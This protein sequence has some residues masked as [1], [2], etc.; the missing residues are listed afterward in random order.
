MQATSCYDRRLAAALNRLSATRPSY[1]SYADI[2]RYR[3]AYDLYQYPAMMVPAMLSDLLSVIN[4]STSG[5]EK[6]CDPFL[7]SGSVLTASML[8][9]M[10]FRGTDV[11]PLA[12]LISKVKSGPYLP[13]VLEASSDRLKCRIKSDRRR[14]YSIDFPGLDK[15]FTSKGILE[16]S[17][18]RRAIRI[19]PKAWCRRFFWVCMAETV[20]LCSNSRTSTY[21]LHIRDN[22]DLEARCGLSPISVFHGILDEN[23][24]KHF[25]FSSIL[26]GRTLL[27]RG[28]FIKEVSVELADCR[29]IGKCEKS[30]LLITSPPY[31][32]NTSTVPYGQ[33]SY[34]PLQCID[35]EDI[36]PAVDVDCISTTHE[37]DSRSL[38]GHRRGAVQHISSLTKLS[39][40]LERCLKKLRPLPPDRSSRVA[41][42]SR[43]LYAAIDPILSRLK[44]NAYMVWIVGNR[45][46]GGVE[47]PTAQIF[48][49]FL[50][51][52][53]TIHVC[54]LD[55]RIPTKRMAAK[56]AISQTMTKEKILVFR[57]GG[58]G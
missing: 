49:D 27:N 4:S 25:D 18:I 8:A 2:S 6:V 41:A 1:W 9:G 45:R 47:V 51:A 26:R 40:H 37:I 15:W 7:G 44:P 42:F 3:S 52:R 35:L 36:D 55:R 30:D 13:S 31:G 58:N 21:K 22:D 32:D 24:R 5:I 28:R 20:R 39:P 48:S 33:H 46:V 56:N 57:N 29:S 23:L 11:N 12:I 10:E 50:L 17:K 38:G 53:G 14:A 43:D 16:L 54:T 19:E 34:L